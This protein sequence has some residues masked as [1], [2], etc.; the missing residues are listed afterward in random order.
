MATPTAAVTSSGLNPS[1]VGGK[2][3]AK[4]GGVLRRSSGNNT[5]NG[6]LYSNKEGE[7][8]FMQTFPASG[9]PGA[10][11]PGPPKLTIAQQT[12]AMP[13]LSMPVRS[14]MVNNG[15]SNPGWLKNFTLTGS[16]SDAV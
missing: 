15:C 16:N 1:Q 9:G 2:W 10:F 12:P 11:T 6:Y 13:P 14:G 8:I 3:L 5:N 7:K 4:G